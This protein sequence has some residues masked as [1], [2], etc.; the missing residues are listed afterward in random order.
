[1]RIDPLEAGLAS[2]LTLSAL[3]VACGDGPT[4]PGRQSPL[5]PSPVRVE[6]G[7][8]RSVAPGETAQLAMTLRLSDGSSQDVTAETNWQSRTTQFVSIDAGG[9]VT[10]LRVGD[11]SI[12][13]FYR[14]QGALN[15]IKELIVVPTGTFRL[16]GVVNEVEGT[17]VPVPGARVDVTSSGGNSLST[18]TGDDGAYRVYGVA[19]DTQIRVTKN[20]YQVSARQVSIQDHGIQNFE[21]Q[22]T[23]PRID[24][25]GSYT[26]TLTA[27]DSC[28]GRLP[29]EALRRTY[30]ATVVQ[31]GA[32]LETTLTGGTFA[33]NRTGRGGSFLGRVEPTLLAF[34]LNLQPYYNYYPYVPSYYPDI[35]EQLTAGYLVVS[36]TVSAQASPQRITGPLIGS[37][38]I[39]PR[40]P[41]SGSSQSPSV[42][43]DSRAHQFVLT[44]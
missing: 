32:R 42:L 4:N 16:T 14:A 10:G 35:V 12:S 21:L 5:P 43:C 38:A 9:R 30:A 2:A 34:T 1:V 23:N 26:L 18:T 40:D 41:R 13:G 37:M 44:R 8:P 20:G 31:R 19:G 29:D 17:T 15:A 25:S 39:W 22:I 11:G 27:A 36:G 3:F 24:V 7:G 33:I 28:R 6:I